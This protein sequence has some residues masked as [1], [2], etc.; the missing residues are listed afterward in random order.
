[1]AADIDHGIDRARPAE[2]LA[3][4]LVADGPLRPGCGTV[5]KAQLLVL[6]GTWI[7]MPIGALTTQLLPAPPASSRQ[8]LT[9]ESSLRRLATTEPAPQI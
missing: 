4:G 3:A 8:T 7:A 9:F 6:E 2:R 5:S 1:M